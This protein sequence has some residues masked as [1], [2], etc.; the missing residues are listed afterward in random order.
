MKKVRYKMHMCKFSLKLF[1]LEVA[2]HALL[3]YKQNKQIKTPKLLTVPSWKYGR[4]DL[5]CT[6]KITIYWQGCVKYV[7]QINMPGKMAPQWK[8]FATPLKDQISVPSTHAVHIRRFTTS[9]IKTAGIQWHL[10][11]FTDTH[12]NTHTHTHKKTKIQKAKA[13]MLIVHDNV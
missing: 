6:W 4:M 7:L 3:L 13:T 8:A 5:L 9:C 11:A 12:T 1:I 10:L 2:V